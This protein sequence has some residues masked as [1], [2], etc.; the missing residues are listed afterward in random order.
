MTINKAKSIT[1]LVEIALSATTNEQIKFSLGYIKKT[2]SE[3]VKNITGLDVDGYECIIDNFAIRH[4]ILHHGNAK[5]EAN[6]GQV[7]VTL[8]YFEKIPEVINNP[9]KITDGG[10]TKVGRRSVILEKRVNGVIVYVEEIRTKRKELAMVTMWIK[11]AW[12]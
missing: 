4:S 6:R 11:K 3:T 12:I 7:A 5:E 1:N 10:K 2:V 9:D 8:D